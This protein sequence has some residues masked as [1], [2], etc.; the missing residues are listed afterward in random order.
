M[1]AFGEV[2]NLKLEDILTAVLVVADQLFALTGASDGE[3]VLVLVGDA[4]L[5]A[6]VQTPS[7]Q[8]P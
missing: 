8:T 6:P 5:G 7:L 1:E 4:A 3:G 2:E